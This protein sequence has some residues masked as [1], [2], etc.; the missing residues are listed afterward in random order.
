MAV[1]ANALIIPGSGTV[2]MSAAN[3]ALPATP[4][5]SF[6]LNGAAP[7]GWQNL[8]HTSK[9]NTISFSREGGESTP[10]D[11]FLASAV[12]TQKASESWSVNVP[13]LQ[14]DENILD[15]AFNGDFDSTTGGYTVPAS[16]APSQAGLFLLM[17]DNTGKL[18]FWLPNTTVSLGDAPSVDTEYF[19]ELPLTASILSAPNAVIAAV[20]G[21]PGIM[22]IFK[23]G[24]TPPPNWAATTAYTVG[25]R[26]KLTG[27]TVLEATVAGTSGSTAPTAPG[28]VGGTVTDGTVT[29]KRTS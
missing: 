9:S 24:L 25:Q 23:T 28:T 6:T 7:N 27:G 5:D 20:N 22:Q 26:V 29:W 13:A 12:R 4:L 2:F 15:L 16:A 1:D 8:G 10:L 18:G 14:F 11:T 21:Q 19:M 17:Q 3:A